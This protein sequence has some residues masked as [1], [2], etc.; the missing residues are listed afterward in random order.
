MRFYNYTKLTKITI[1][2]G[3]SKIGEY[4]F[5]SCSNLTE[6]IFVIPEDW[7]VLMND[8]AVEV[9]NDIADAK[10]AAECLTV[11]FAPYKWEHIDSNK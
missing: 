11:T 3:V 1:V 4:A 2:G 10:I 7:Y 5:D 8:Q 6:I 9:Q